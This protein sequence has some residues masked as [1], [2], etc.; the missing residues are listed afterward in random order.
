[1]SS[2]PNQITFGTDGFRGAVARDFTYDSVRKIAQGLADYIAYK[3][4]RVAEKPTVV[5]GYDRRFLSDRFAAAASDV[6]TA[7]GSCA[8]FPTAAAPQAVS[9]LTASSSGWA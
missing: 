9:Y 2:H 5:V 8:P 7:N 6:L 1:M 3:N 4:M